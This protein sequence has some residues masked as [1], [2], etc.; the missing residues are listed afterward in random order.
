LKF[1]IEQLQ[2]TIQGL[3]RIYRVAGLVGTQ[4]AGCR[5]LGC[6]PREHGPSV[7]HVG[8]QYRA[9]DHPAAHLPVL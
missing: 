6:L 2:R 5:R 1:G 8:H 9:S 3:F 7:S 4:C